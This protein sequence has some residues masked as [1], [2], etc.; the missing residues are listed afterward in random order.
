MA[1]ILGHRLY[2]GEFYLHARQKN[3]VRYRHHN[4]SPV[5]VGSCMYGFLCLHKT[6]RPANDWP[7]SEH[8]AARP[9]QPPLFLFLLCGA[10]RGFS[11][12][13]AL[14]ALGFGKQPPVVVPKELEQ[15]DMAALQGHCVE[16]DGQSFAG[17]V[18]IGSSDA[19]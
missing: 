14:V 9:S 17:I 12:P 6:V 3:R 5:V 11:L 1:V 10:F 18:R 19:L 8:G 15:D 13:F 2:G 16:N 7:K 4:H